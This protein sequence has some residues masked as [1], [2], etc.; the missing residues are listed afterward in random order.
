[1]PVL[2]D[3]CQAHGAHLGERRAGAL[4][5]AAAFSFY[6]SKNLGALGDG[7]AVTT[8]DDEI[9]ATVRSLRMH[10][11]VPGNANRHERLGGAT[12]RLDSLQAAFLRVKLPHL[13]GWIAERRA[14]AELYRDAL[15]DL[16]VELPPADPATGTQVYHLF[17]VIVPGE[18]DR[19]LQELRDSGIG[20]A[21][22]YP[23]ACHLQPAFEYLGYAAGDFPNAER[24]ASNA[25]SLPIFPGITEDEIQRVA[26][27]LSDAL[28]S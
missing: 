27:A 19:I 16:P 17:E 28:P 22:H 25:I 20:A 4:G 21:V 8:S 11:S 1:V 24:I 9:A 12:G 5:T 7:G 2:E 18:R 14:A 23:T 10:G 6:P 3:A 26:A 13:D 15:A